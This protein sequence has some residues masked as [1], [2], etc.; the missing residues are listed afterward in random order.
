M[1]INCSRC[2][3]R[4]KV[5][6]NHINQK[7]REFFDKTDLYMCRWCRIEL[8]IFSNTEAIIK[9]LKEIQKNDRK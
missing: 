7:L 8:G 5:S 4:I 6:I 2:N 1:K 9:K 3:R